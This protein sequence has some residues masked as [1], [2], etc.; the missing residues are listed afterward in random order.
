MTRKIYS[1]I[2]PG[3]LLHMI[4]LRSDSAPAREDIVYPDNFIQCASLKL[5]KGQTFKPH[6][7][8][9]KERSLNVISQE[10]WVCLKG[11]VMCHFFDIDGSHLEDN[12]INEGGASFTLAGGHTYT[13]LQD[14]TIVMEYKTGPYEGI[15]NDKVMI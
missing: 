3:L 9:I 15:E 11:S 13:C 10:S 8:I 2:Q 7:H 1:K 12:T 4:Y 14:D 5:S 6:K